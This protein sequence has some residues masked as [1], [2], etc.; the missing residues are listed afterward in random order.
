MKKTRGELKSKF[1]KNSKPTEQDFVDVFDSLLHKDDPLPNANLVVATQTDAEQGVNNAKYMTPLRVLQAIKKLTRLANLPDLKAD[2]EDLINSGSGQP[3]FGIL[4][5]DVVSVSNKLKATVNVTNALNLGLQYSVDDVNYQTSNIFENLTST[6]WFYVRQSNNFSKKVA[7]QKKTSIYARISDLTIVLVGANYTVTVLVNNPNGV[8]LEYRLDTGA[9]Q[10]SNVFTGVVSGNHTFSIRNKNATTEGDSVIRAVGNSALPNNIVPKLTITPEVMWNRF[11]PNLIP[12]F[13]IPTANHAEVSQTLPVRWF[14]WDAAARNCFGTTGTTNTEK[15]TSERTNMYAKGI[16]AIGQNR[17]R[18]CTEIESDGG[19]CFVGTTPVMDG[20][21]VAG[22]RFFYNP[23]GDL[24]GW[25][26]FAKANVDWTSSRLKLALDTDKYPLFLMFQEFL[27][28]L[29]FE[30]TTNSRDFIGTLSL[31]TLDRS[32]GYVAQLY[33]S[34][35][36]SRSPLDELYQV[37]NIYRNDNWRLAITSGTYQGQVQ[38]GNKRVICTVYIQNPYEITLPQNYQVKDQLGNNWFN[39]NHFGGLFTGNSSFQSVPN[40]PHWATVV[41][42][43]VEAN[44]LET[45]STNHILVV[46]ENY[47]NGGQGYIYSPE[48]MQY[49]DNKYIQEFSRYGNILNDGNGDYTFPLFNESIP[50]FIAEGQILLSYFCGAKGVRLLRE[51][52]LDSIPHTKD[53]AHP[54]RGSKYNDLDYANLDLENNVYSLHAMWRLAQKV[55]LE[56]GAQYSFFDICDGSEIILNSETEVN[57]GAGFVKYKATDWSKY[58]KTPVRAVV[59]L[60]KNVIFI[61]AFQA[62]GAEQNSVTVRYN[63][64]SKNFSKTITVPTGELVI[65]AYSLS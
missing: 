7:F 42:G 48:F 37:N 62:Y 5:V 31:A 29:A 10:D 9:W 18:N 59:N 13:T 58:Q 28:G 44:Y 21:K 46:L 53:A 30:S 4:G 25:I 34:A 64:N 16:T 40:V 19:N 26:A 8:T 43:L 36:N 11:S 24:T 33:L 12:N 3:A 17:L 22:S 50:N 20:W 27:G 1:Q 23:T 65:Q 41:G 47:N 35:L 39:A 61:L 56:S 32:K 51:G 38:K 15:A 57:Y 54:R 60:A 14:I 49:R 63:Q 6:D 55:Q 45:G 52:E 2:V